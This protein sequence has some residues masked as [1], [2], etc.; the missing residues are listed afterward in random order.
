M[1]SVA[2][3]SVQLPHHD[4]IS[5]TE[6]VQ[7]PVQLWTVYPGPADPLVFIDSFA[8]SCFQCADLQIGVLVGKADAGISEACHHFSVL[9]KDQC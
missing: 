9:S 5:W 7:E 6:T 1:A 3:Q 8:P 4:F 2:S